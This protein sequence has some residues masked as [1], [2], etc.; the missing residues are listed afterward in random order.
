MSLFLLIN[1]KTRYRYIG[2]SLIELLV[3]ISIV[4]ILILMAVGGYSS[5]LTRVKSE[6]RADDLKQSLFFAKSAAIQ[7]GGKVRLC[8][9]SDGATCTG[10]LDAGWIV[11]KD[12]DG[13]QQLDNDDAL[14]RVFERSSNVFAI[15]LQNSVGPTAI[16]GVTFNYKGYANVALTAS[17]SNSL[18]SQNFSMT[19]SGYIP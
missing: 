1:L 8:G 13:S 2:F 19:R 17:L 10:S 12:N 15:S 6:E 18:A 7:H 3:V 14:I 9:S 4:G 11:F 5:W 16:S